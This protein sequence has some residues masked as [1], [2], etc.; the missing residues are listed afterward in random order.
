MKIDGWLYPLGFLVALMAAGVLYCHTPTAS[1]AA[2]WVQAVGSIG[3]IGI[4][5][6]VSRRQY[7]DSR[8]LE[9]S[10]TRADA[11]KDLEETRAFVQS[12]QVEVGALWTSFNRGVGPEL[13]ALSEGRPFLTQY[14]NTADVLTIYNGSAWRVGKVD[15]PE[16]RQAMVSTVMLLKG[17]LRALQENN[18]LI[19]RHNDLFNGA[20]TPQRDN[21]LG[22]V[23]ATL[24]HL[25][26]ML[27]RQDVTIREA[28]DDMHTRCEAWLHDTRPAPSK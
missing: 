5:I 14:I 22:N 16:L 12:I 15:D 4:A 28:I 9:A 13:R 27:R 8:E 11:A 26:N 17:F 6:W 20:P 2:A 1:D 23:M 3:A 21:Q 18:I 19:N 7:L 24:V 25:A 10:R